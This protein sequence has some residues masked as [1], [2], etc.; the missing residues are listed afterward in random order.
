MGK[1]VSG[2]NVSD[3]NDA[4]DDSESVRGR[5]V[6]RVGCSLP[7]MHFARRDSTVALS[8]GGSECALTIVGL[9]V[10]EGT[11]DKVNV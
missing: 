4:V 11:Q 9:R 1:V 5:W 6:P 8:A 7:E 3:S 10:T 2:C